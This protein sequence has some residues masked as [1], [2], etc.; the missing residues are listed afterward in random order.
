MNKSIQVTTN[1]FK[2][3]IYCLLCTINI[4][5]SVF[6]QN[7]GI[8][9]AGAAPPD[10]AAGLDINFSTK[11][12]LLPRVA[13]V[14]TTNFLPLAAHVAGMVIY[15]T[16]ATGDVSPGLYFNDGTKWIATPPKAI[17]GGDMNTWDGVKW[18]TI[19]IG[20]PGQLLQI[21]GSGV[22]EWVGAGYASLVTTI[23]S[24]ITSTSATSG[25]IVS[26]EGGSPVTTRGV[27]WAITSSPTIADSNTTDG[28]G[29]GSFTSIVTG[30]TTGITYY[31]RAY[32]TNSTGTSYGNLIVFTAL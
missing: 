13:L 26:I 2:K 5:L 1:R 24:E 20:Q 22:P 3:F 10:P 19:S 23:V 6:S 9:P 17:S 27:C 15:N 28:S 8:S 4:S 11:G 31:L 32:A 30:L 25:G 16:A 18:I 12:F 7:V 29:T 21:N 14:A